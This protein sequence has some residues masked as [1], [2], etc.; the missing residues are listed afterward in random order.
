MDRG[1]LPPQLRVPGKKNLTNVQ[2]ETRNFF[3]KMFTPGATG[4]GQSMSG[5]AEG[6]AAA[7]K[8]GIIVKTEKGGK[9]VRIKKKKTNSTQRIRKKRGEDNGKTNK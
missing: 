4:G 3:K 7:K 2:S 1:M 6:D 8:G 5:L 9:A